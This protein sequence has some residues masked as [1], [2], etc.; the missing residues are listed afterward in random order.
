MRYNRKFIEARFAMAMQAIG[1]PVGESWTKQDDGSHRA[2]VGVHFLDYAP[3]YGGYR[4]VRLH[5][6]GGAEAT[7]FGSNR[8]AAAAFVALLDGIIGAA[9]IVKEQGR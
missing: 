1:A 9:R 5:N 8:Y 2:N 6:E 3:I 4:I 7:P